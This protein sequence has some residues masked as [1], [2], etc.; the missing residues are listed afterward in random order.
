[1]SKCDEAPEPCESLSYSVQIKGLL[2]ISDVYRTGQID[3]VAS[4]NE[5]Y[6]RPLTALGNASV[7]KGYQ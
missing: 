2:P 7:Y 6:V 1:M 4:L 3:K 5:M